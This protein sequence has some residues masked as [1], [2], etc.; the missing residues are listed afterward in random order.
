[1]WADF[2]IKKIKRRFQGAGGFDHAVV[3]IPDKSSKTDDNADDETTQPE[4]TI[5]G[6]SEENIARKSIG[7]FWAFSTFVF[8][9][10]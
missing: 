9:I 4:E 3:N 5:S 8:F 1:M 10:L 7:K 6:A 2:K